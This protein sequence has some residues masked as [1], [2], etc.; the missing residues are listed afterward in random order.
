MSDGGEEFAAQGEVPADVAGVGGEGLG[1][2]DWAERHGDGLHACGDG[3]GEAAGAV[4]DAVRV[5]AGG[6]DVEGLGDAVGLDVGDHLRIGLGG[7]GGE[8]GDGLG[9]PLGCGGGGLLGLG[10]GG[11]VCSCSV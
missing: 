7:G 5:V 2:D 8:D 9:R 1:A 3:G 4:G 6:G 11:H 10:L